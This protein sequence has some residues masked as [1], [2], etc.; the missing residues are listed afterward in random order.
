MTSNIFN[1]RSKIKTRTSV[2]RTE[3]QTAAFFTAEGIELKP[4][5]SEQDIEI[6]ITLIL[7]LAFLL[8][9]RSL[10]YVC[11]SPWTIR[12]YAGFSTAEES[13]AFIDVILLQDKRTIDCFR[14]ADTPWV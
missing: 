14:F 8:F 13:N 12:Q 10:Y 3:N 6:S 11:A 7:V 9:T 4:T 2:A 1:F 5:Y